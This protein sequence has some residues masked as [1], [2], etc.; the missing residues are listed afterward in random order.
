MKPKSRQAR[1]KAKVKRP[2]DAVRASRDGHEFHEAWARL[3]AD[4][5]ALARSLT[6]TNVEPQRYFF[7][8]PRAMEPPFA[9][10]SVTGALDQAQVN[11][12]LLSHAARYRRGFQAAAILLGNGGGRWLGLDR[13]FRE[14]SWHF[15]TT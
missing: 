5:P 2:T 8:K 12:P 11:P 6:E 10:A 1:A 7:V 3:S 14:S 13:R 4:H 15:S 9:V